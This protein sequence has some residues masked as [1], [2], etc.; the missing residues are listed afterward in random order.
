LVSR[1]GLMRT[2]MLLQGLGLPYFGAAPPCFI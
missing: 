2:D 1:T